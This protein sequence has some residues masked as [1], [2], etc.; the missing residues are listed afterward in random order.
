MST[1]MRIRAIGRGLVIVS[2]VL[3]ALRVAVYVA[4]RLL[5]L[6]GYLGGLLFIA[7][8]VLWFGGSVMTGYSEHAPRNQQP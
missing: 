6:A 3:M 7:G 8:I 2:L 5:I 4:G 1:S